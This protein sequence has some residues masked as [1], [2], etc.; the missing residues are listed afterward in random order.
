[1]IN[2][3]STTTKP[4]PLRANPKNQKQKNKKKKDIKKKKKNMAREQ[5]SN[6]PSHPQEATYAQ[7]LRDKNKLAK[8]Y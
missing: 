8:D 5:D 3:T 2:L 6:N 1:M 7:I 4:F